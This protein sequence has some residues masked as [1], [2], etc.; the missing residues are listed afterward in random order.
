MD[1][2]PNTHIM[3]LPCSHILHRECG[4]QHL[5]YSKACPA[6]NE[7]IDVSTLKKN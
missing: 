4:M 1:I 2:Q 7:E 6:C 5:L 3:H